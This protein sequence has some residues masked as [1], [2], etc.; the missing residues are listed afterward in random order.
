VKVKVFE[1]EVA[2]QKE[3]S[4]ELLTELRY[5]MAETE[6][7]RKRHKTELDQAKTYA[8][9]KFAKS[10]VEVADNLERAKDTVSDQEIEKNNAFKNFYDGVKLT[11]DSL[12]QILAQNDISR[13]DP[14][15][16]MFDPKYHEAMF[17]MDSDE[18]KD[19]IVHLMQPGW[20]I[21]DRLL[22][23]ARV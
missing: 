11:D 16:E 15:G 12:Q 3:R 9:T 4:E 22:R 17:Q 14:M 21:K 6:N 23:A 13:I 10:I 7:L 19:T 5:K 1:C 2:E 18:P 8:I 20:R